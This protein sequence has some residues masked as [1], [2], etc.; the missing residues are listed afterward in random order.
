MQKIEEKLA[1]I[2]NNSIPKNDQLKFP[3]I[4]LSN[5]QSS[6]TYCSDNKRL[7]KNHL[8]GPEPFL[9]PCREDGGVWT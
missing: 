4:P 5:Y 3:S 9:V 6:S 2:V 7:M 8:Y 1:N